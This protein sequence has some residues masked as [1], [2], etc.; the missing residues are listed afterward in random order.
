MWGNKIPF[1]VIFV[2]LRKSLRIIMVT[3]TMTYKACVK[4]F[5]LSFHV[6]PRKNGR[7]LHAGYGMR[8]IGTNSPGEILP[9]VVYMDM[10]TLK[11][12]VFSRFGHK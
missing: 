4:P 3:I 6:K 7:Q 2:L 8:I 1:L 5:T 9:C 10:C 12:R 11:G